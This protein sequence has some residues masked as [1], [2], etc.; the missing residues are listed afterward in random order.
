M[1]KNQ[2]LIAA[3]LA[4]AGLGSAN[5]A[6][7]H[8]TCAPMEVTHS[9]AV[10]ISYTLACDA[11]P[12]K[13]TYT[14]S[15]PS[16][17]AGVNAHY[18][19]E[20]RNPDGAHLT[21]QRQVRLLEP[22][23]LGQSLLAEA[24]ML[25]DGNLALRECKEVGCTLYRPLAAN[26]KNVKA[27]TVVTPE[28]Q[29]LRAEHASLSEKLEQEKVLAEKLQAQVG[30]LNAELQVALRAN[31]AL[32]DQQTADLQGLESSYA[33]KLTTVQSALTQTQG[34]AAEIQANQAKDLEQ[35]RVDLK[36]SNDL[37]AQAQQQVGGLQAR[38]TELEQALQK[39]QAEAAQAAAAVREA[40][41]AEISASL[42][43]IKEAQDELTQLKTAQGQA[44]QA[45]GAE[46]AAAQDEL[47]ALREEV[48]QLKDLQAADLQKGAEQASKLDTITGEKAQ[49][50]M[51]RDALTA[52]HAEVQALMA[53]LTQALASS[54][55]EIQRVTAEWEAAVRESQAVAEETIDLVQA[56]EGAQ[57][58]I[59]SKDA[60]LAQK[61]LVVEQLQTQLQ[62]SKLT[63]QLAGQAAEVANME[64]DS[65]NLQVVVLERDLQL[66]SQQLADAQA[67]LA[68]NKAAESTESN[69]A[70]PEISADSS[71]CAV[72]PAALV[73]VELPAALSQ[74]VD[75]PQAER[76]AQPDTPE[77]KTIEN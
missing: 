37:L 42:V 17:S 25:D 71:H 3:L 33:A 50:V 52:K 15:V 12:W 75:Q 27:T 22:S 45:R 69:Q 57:K 21:Q 1:K 58:T 41:A 8:Q 77:L 63:Q 73:S 5:A 72:A 48:A 55:I 13:L 30:S 47:K 76:A 36:T 59:E 40:H 74:Q 70:S 11:G 68:A 53:D 10:G 66:V 54:D 26:P 4:I 28:L 56:Y 6:A 43:K 7:T 19:L 16:G 23:K 24:V 65:L 20:I 31:L 51:E 18:R 9:S 35:L 34:Q 49:L 62:A 32:Q 14:G 38:V 67:Q 39:Y 46:V 61:A 60:E 44:D 64:V 2:L 29:Q